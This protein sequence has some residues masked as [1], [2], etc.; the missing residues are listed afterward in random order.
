[1]ILETQ[2]VVIIRRPSST[3]PPSAK[4]AAS[5]TPSA[6]KTPSSPTTTTPSHLIITKNDSLAERVRKVIFHWILINI[7]IFYLK[8]GFFIL[9][10]RCHVL[11]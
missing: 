7:H 4:P 2:S 9:V 8:L 1:M 11:F 6:S 3:P 5:T 10:F